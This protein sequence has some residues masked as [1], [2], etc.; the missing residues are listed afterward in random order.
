MPV[1]KWGLIVLIVLLT[2]GAGLTLFQYMDSSEEA[3]ARE[4]AAP[5]DSDSMVPDWIVDDL[6]TRFPEPAKSMVTKDRIIVVQ[7]KMTPP[8]DERE[9]VPQIA[10]YVTLDHLNGA[11]VL[12]AKQNGV[13]Q[14]VYQKMEPVHGLQVVGHGQYVVLTSGFGG[15]GIQENKL[16][17]IRHT[18]AGYQE[19]WS[20]VAHTHQARETI[21]V[22][23][24]NVQ[25]DLSN[26]TM[27]YF[28][29]E[30]TLEATG[31]TLMEKSSYEVLRY[32][33]KTM[34][35]TK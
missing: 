22:V 9:A 11:F 27:V 24:G 28:R 25:F 12:Y 35:F 14:P 10:A 30:R 5:R 23:D 29:L 8:T 26:D 18:P 21:E 17:V 33:E 20:G 7:L 32:N 4:S 13:Y 6:R 16:Y 3:F 31:V 2:A 34:R 1:W 15:S 19:V